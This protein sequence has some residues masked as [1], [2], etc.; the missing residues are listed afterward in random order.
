MIC[1]VR[2]AWYEDY[3]CSSES[4]YMYV[5][6]TC[7]NV[8]VI[9]VVTF[10]VCACVH[11]VVSEC[12]WFSVCVCVFTYR[13]EV[14]LYKAVMPSRPQRVL[15]KPEVH[16]YTCMYNIMYNVPVHVY[17]FRLQYLCIYY[18]HVHIYMYH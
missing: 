12:V 15:V 17:I 8:N 6:C 1:S 18:V 14:P 4:E 11:V 3:W 5:Q 16:V 10:I 13:I 2:R 7:M 9:H